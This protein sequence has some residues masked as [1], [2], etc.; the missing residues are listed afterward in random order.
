MLLA[1]GRGRRMGRLTDSK[2]KPMLRVGNKTLLEHQLDRLAKADYHDVIINTSYLGKTIQQHLCNHPTRIRFS[3]ERKRLETAGGIVK[4]LPFLGSKFLLLN[5]DVWCEHDLQ[6]PNMGNA[7]AHLI[8]VDNPDHNSNG[9]FTFAQ[10]RLGIGA[11]T[12][13]TY[14]GIGWF[15]SDFFKGISHGRRPLGPL[16]RQA[17]K[18]GLVSGEHYRGRWV[19]VGTPERLQQVK[20][21]QRL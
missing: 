12:R 4:T 18:R 11:G 5:S 2:P 17:I 13:L 10:N 1:A 8:L 21:L 20:N 19:D 16:L 6:T 9:D 15:R 3:A 14:S 7:L